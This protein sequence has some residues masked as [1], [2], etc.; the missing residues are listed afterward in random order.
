MAADR[1]FPTGQI[2]QFI[3]VAT[4]E[5]FTVVTPIDAC[6]CDISMVISMYPGGH[7]VMHMQD[8]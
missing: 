1:N 4:V 5:V 3:S 6:V 8:P 7:P 2:T